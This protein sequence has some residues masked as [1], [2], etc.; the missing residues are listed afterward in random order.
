[1]SFHVEDRFAPGPVSKVPVSWF[2]NVGH[3]LNNLVG[4]MGVKVCRDM[5][6]PQIMLDA[7]TAK[8]ALN[9]PEL[10]PIAVHSAAGQEYDDA[11]AVAARAPKDVEQVPVDANG[12]PVDETDAEKTARIGTSKLAAR[13]DHT[14]LDPVIH[15][16]RQTLDDMFEVDGP[17]ANLV[18]TL[19][20]YPPVFDP[21]G[22]FIGL[23][24]T[25]V[26]ICKF[27]AVVD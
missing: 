14:H 18:N 24:D 15:Q 22:R 7:E 19:K 5:E 10:C 21:G 2:N 4:S 20:F 26:E 1:M 3:F 17:D 12:D 9:I 27:Y 11:A 6:P 13:A 25:S 8:D 16:T 23:S